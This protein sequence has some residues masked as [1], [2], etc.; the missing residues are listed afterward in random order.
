MTLECSL[1]EMVLRLYCLLLKYFQKSQGS[2][3]I[4]KDLNFKSISFQHSLSTTYQASHIEKDC[5]ILFLW[6]PNNNPL[7]E[8]TGC[9]TSKRE[10]LES[11]DSNCESTFGVTF[12]CQLSTIFGFLTPVALLRLHAPG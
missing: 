3:G 10:Y 2:T 6:P 5:V 1:C 9:S 11:Q 8:V 12:S 4:V 7:Q